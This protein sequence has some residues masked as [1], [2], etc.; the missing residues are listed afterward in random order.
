MEI[1]KTQIEEGFSQLIKNNELVYSLLDNSD[2]Q[3][4][5]LFIS[6]NY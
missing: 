1:E 6:V 3:N 5:K 4:N 2:N